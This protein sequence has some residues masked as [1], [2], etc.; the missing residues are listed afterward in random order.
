[1]EDYRIVWMKSRVY[2]ALGLTDDSLFD[3]MLARGESEM[4][5]ELLVSLDKPSKQYS[6]SLIFYPLHRNVEK[7]VEIVEGE[8]YTFFLQKKVSKRG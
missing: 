5:Q 1:M 3:N 8:C 7:M 4:T 2:T 6:P